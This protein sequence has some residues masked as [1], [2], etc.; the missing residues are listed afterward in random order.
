MALQDF[1]GTDNIVFLNGL[2][3]LKFFRM[4]TIDF[5]GVSTAIVTPLIDGRIDFDSLEPLVDSQIKAGIR[6]LVAVGTTGESP[7]LG[8]EEHIEVIKNI[9][10]FAGGKIPVVAG[11]GSNSTTEAVDYTRKAVDAGADAIL[12]VTPYYNKPSQE[13]LYRHFAAV[14]EATEKP[15]MLYSIPGRCVVEIGV[16]TCKRLYENYPHINSIKEAGGS[17]DRVAA[18][19]R[20]LGEAYQVLSGD[21]NMTLPFMAMGGA[22]V[23]SVASNLY[24]AELVDMVRRARDGKFSEALKMHQRLAQFFRDLF[25]EPNPV[26]IKF[27]MKQ[28]GIIRSDEVRLPLSP[29]SVENREVLIESMHQ[30]DAGHS[31]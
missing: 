12:Q 25:I 9:V 17:C 7:T 21:D 30:V 20:E 26:P 4:N 2:E 16:D 11:T 24:P 18:L 19:K 1:V 31:T 8:S 23:V 27:L 13:G 3:S 22:G 15:I 29:L 5:S 14:A 6:A 28:K 10:E